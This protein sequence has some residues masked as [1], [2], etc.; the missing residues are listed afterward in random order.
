MDKKVE[1]IINLYNRVVEGEV[2]VKAMKLQDLELMK[3]LFREIWKISGH[4]LQV[5]LNQ[6]ENS[7]MTGKRKVMFWLR[8]R[9]RCLR[10]GRYLQYVRSF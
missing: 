5:I 7:S 10:V 6:T 3:D 2:L 1:R 8:I 4:I 9:K